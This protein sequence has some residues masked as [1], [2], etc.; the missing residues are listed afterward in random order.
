MVQQALCHET[1][2]KAWFAFWFDVDESLRATSI[3]WWL[4]SADDY[5]EFADDIVDRADDRDDHLQAAGTQWW[6]E[7]EL[8]V[9]AS[10]W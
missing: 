8:K 6:L 5:S 2:K 1:T 3:Q 7:E 10:S 9:I 4:V